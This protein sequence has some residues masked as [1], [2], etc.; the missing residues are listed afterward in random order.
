MKLSAICAVNVLL[1][2]D[3]LIYQNPFVRVPAGSSLAPLVVASA[4]QPFYARVYAL[5]QTREH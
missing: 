3:C 1:Q 2:Q 4:A 5:L